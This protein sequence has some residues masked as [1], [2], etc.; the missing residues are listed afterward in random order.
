VAETSSGSK[1]ASRA[2]RRS[3]DRTK[4]GPTDKRPPTRKKPI[5]YGSE[6]PRVYTP[7]LRE[8]TPETSL[9]F[10]V[11]EFAETV[12]L[13]TLLPWQ[14]WLLIHMLELLPDNS[15]R[16]RTVI[17]LVARQNGKSTLSQVLGLWFMYVY[18]IALVLGTAQDLDTA[19]EVWEGA[20]NLATET[21]DDE[22]PVRPEL[23]DLVDKVVQVN[24]KKALVLKTKKR[25]K[26]KAANRRA[27]RGL[28][29]DVIFLDELRE[30]QSWDAWGS[31]TKTTIARAFALILCMSNAGDST[32]IV[33]RHLRKLGHAAVG[34]PDGIVKA[35]EEDPYADE[36]TDEE[37][38]EFDDDAAELLED[39]EDDETLG[40]FEWSAKPGR[41]VHDRDGWC[42][43]NPSLGYTIQERTLASAAKTDPEWV[44][45]TECLCQWPGG[46]LS[47]PFPPMTW[48][49]GRWAPDRPTDTPPKIVGPLK[50]CVV[51]SHDRKTTS[52]VVA[53]RREDGLPQVEV[54]AQRAG[55]A[56]VRGWFH[57]DKPTRKRIE[58]ITGRKAG[59]EGALLKDL[60]SDWTD[61][62]GVH[63][64]GLPVHF[65]AGEDLPGWT[66]EFYDLVKVGDLDENDQ[67]AGLRHLPQPALD[68]AAGNAV[69]KPSGTRFIWDDQKSPVDI[70]TLIGATG[71]VGLLLTAKPPERSVYEDHD[72]LV[73]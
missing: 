58:Q 4:S 16:F 15:L 6:V 33:L 38:E 43:A 64:Q 8:L 22:N 1:A 21:D 7:P 12:L 14:K 35:D 67:P 41:S 71:A 31:I 28:S 5:R 32:S 63:H 18:G 73:L 13:L 30:H 17:V 47:G 46:T 23:H 19:E 60:E 61:E 45:R 2:R 27:G 70:S 34:D 48:E 53:G 72:L 39:L 44:F 52:I 49:A 56:W 65:W 37:L 42:E 10:S 68:V 51:M 40:I 26:V 54:V 9:G 29:G 50:A 25:W 20:V 24:G 11:I 69:T 36:P 3:S 57:E 66:G 55:T 62:K 59:P